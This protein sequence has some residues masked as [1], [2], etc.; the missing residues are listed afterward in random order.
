MYVC[1]HV[2]R[3]ILTIIRYWS[4]DLSARGWPMPCCIPSWILSRPCPFR[5]IGSGICTTFSTRTGRTSRTNVPIKID[6]DEHEGCDE[7]TFVN[8]VIDVSRRTIVTS[9]E[10]SRSGFYQSG[11]C[12]RQRQ[13]CWYFINN[14]RLRCQ[15]DIMGIYGMYRRRSDT[16]IKIIMS[17]M[18]WHWWR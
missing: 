2:H 6:V 16:N 11:H 15:D 4:S 7:D 14:G 1:M 9:V 18:K 10:S 5:C 12:R 17:T 13:R 3:Q 8:T